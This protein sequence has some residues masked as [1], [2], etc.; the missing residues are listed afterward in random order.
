M[1]VCATYSPAGGVPA[2]GS[3]DVMVFVL[4]MAA[5]LNDL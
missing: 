4:D 5:A 2:P 1:I 3:Y